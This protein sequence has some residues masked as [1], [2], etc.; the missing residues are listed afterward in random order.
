MPTAPALYGGL[1]RN[2]A[3]NAGVGVDRVQRQKVYWCPRHRHSMED[4]S[5]TPPRTRSR[6]I[7]NDWAMGDE[8]F[9]ITK[10]Y[11]ETSVLKIRWKS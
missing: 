2:F 8:V 10:F 5:G 1:L 7:F 6:R 9:A 4:C 11:I 3:E